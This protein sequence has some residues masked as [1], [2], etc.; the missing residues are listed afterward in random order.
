M[1]KYDVDLAKS[2]RNVEIFVIDQKNEEKIIDIDAD[3]VDD[4]IEE[5]HVPNKGEGKKMIIIGGLK[6]MTTTPIT[7]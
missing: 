6:K 5:L 1:H 3:V 4:I 7:T 2:Q